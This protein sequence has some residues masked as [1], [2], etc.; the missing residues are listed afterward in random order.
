MNRK[1]LVLSALAAATAILSGCATMRSVGEV[2][3]ASATYPQE[4][5]RMTPDGRGGYLISR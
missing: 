1:L 4:Y 3:S 2:L 5:S